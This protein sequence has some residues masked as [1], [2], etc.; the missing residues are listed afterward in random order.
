[1]GDQDKLDISFL[2]LFKVVDALRASGMKSMGKRNIDLFVNLTWR[3]EKAIFIVGENEDT[4]PDG[5]CLKY[6]AQELKATIPA[7]SVLVQNM[8]RKN[9]FLRFPSPHD[10]RRRC[11]RLTPFGRETLDLMR[12]NIRKVANE[13]LD[14]LSQQE[15][16]SFAQII[17]HFHEKLLGRE[18]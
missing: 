12:K 8:V 16:A 18:E 13:L 10:R 2:R 4:I 1:M 17:A 3:Q 15:R 14:G 7:T 11:L 6:L 9:L 5:I